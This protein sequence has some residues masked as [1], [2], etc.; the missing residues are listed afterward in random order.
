MPGKNAEDSDDAQTLQTYF[1]RSRLQ[2][3]SLLV[4]A[5]GV[6]GIVINDIV[7]H[8]ADLV[9]AEAP[10]KVQLFASPHDGGAKPR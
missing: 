1:L 7:R 9:R 4:I 6:F 8:R 2:A 3:A 5:S 10:S